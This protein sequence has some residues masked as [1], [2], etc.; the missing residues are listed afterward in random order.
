MDRS[1]TL[2][3]LRFD[4][5]EVWLTPGRFTIG[6][7]SGCHVV[8]DDPLVSRKH[9]RIVVTRQGATIEDLHS[10]NGVYVNGE[11]LLGE[12]RGL[13]DGDEVVV[14]TRAIAI[15]RLRAERPSLWPSDDTLSGI[16]PVVPAEF[17]EEGPSADTRRAGL[18]GLLAVTADRAL[19]A[20]GVTDAEQL[21]GELLMAVLR[22]AKSGKQ[23]A[24]EISMQAMHDA[25]RLAESTA[26]SAWF[27]YVVELLYYL[28]QLPSSELLERME[29]VLEQLDGVDL[30]RLA[31]YTAGVG[32]MAGADASQ[33]RLARATQLLTARAGRLRVS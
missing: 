14:G 29:V 6:R 31:R 23:V 21:L 2:F 18:V 19:R 25:L 24:P 26:T 30:P 15:A 10:I 13:E 8:L 11:P 5:H 9:A 4:G 7:S 3:K 12:P 1:P 17:E 16:D 20:G 32:A 22:D 28:K 27:D 33:Q